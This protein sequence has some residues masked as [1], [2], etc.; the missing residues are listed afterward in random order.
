MGQEGL[1]RFELNPENVESGF[2]SQLATNTFS[3]LKKL[4]TNTLP[5]MVGWLLPCSASAIVLR[6][7]KEGAK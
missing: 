6:N 2:P 5:F 4:A 7:E 3:L 1:A